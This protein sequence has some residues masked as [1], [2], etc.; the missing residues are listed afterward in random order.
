MPSRI[1]IDF[2]RALERGTSGAVPRCGNWPSAPRYRLSRLRARRSLPRER[3]IVL[4][5]RGERFT[6]SASEFARELDSETLERLLFL[7]LVLA[8][9]PE[10][11]PV[12]QSVARSPKTYWLPRLAIE[13]SRTAA[14]AV[15]SQISRAISR[16]ELPIGW[17]PHQTRGAAGPVRQK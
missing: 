11:S 6:D 5:N 14:L 12:R 9:Q 15:R 10:Q 8:P 2:S 13:P 3:S 16:R 4:F 17:P 1:G 7:P